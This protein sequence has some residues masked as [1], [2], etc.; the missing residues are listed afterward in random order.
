MP[1][2]YLP[3]HRANRDNQNVKV[4]RLP[5][6]RVGD[7]ARRVGTSARM[8]RYAEQLG[9]VAP[10]RTA[11]G[12]RDYGERDL[13][14]VAGALRLQERYGAPPA[15][16]AFGLRALEDPEVAGSLRALARL[17]RRADPD[18]VAALDFETAKARR[19]LRLAS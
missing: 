11:A 14:A 5:A 18:P 1:K 16:L 12:Y 8:L 2:S 3:R 4:C 15:A 19:L 17:I 13:Q 7:A 6:M 10:A 9:L